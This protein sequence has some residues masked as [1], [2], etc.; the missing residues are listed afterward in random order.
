MPIS[1]KEAYSAE[2]V[3]AVEVAKEAEI[4][5]TIK[6]YEGLIDEFIANTFYD[7]R[8]TE[9][10]IYDSRNWWTMSDR[11]LQSLSKT[12]GDLGWTL[13]KKTSPSSAFSFLTIRPT[14][15]AEEPNPEPQY[16]KPFYAFWR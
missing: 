2:K 7:G 15:A 8:T 4:Q 3:A 5:N 9:H 14:Q 13:E 10:E 1:P 12:Y 6:R 11:I 16:R